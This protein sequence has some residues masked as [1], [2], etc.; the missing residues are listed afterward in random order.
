MIGTAI[1]VIWC[2]TR[3]SEEAREDSSLGPSEGVWDTLILGIQPP[4]PYSAKYSTHPL[5]G[6]LGP[7]GGM[8]GLPR[9]LGGGGN[10]G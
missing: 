6:K 1:T 8:R 7:S 9:A 2:L 3:S 10:E 4:S 5:N